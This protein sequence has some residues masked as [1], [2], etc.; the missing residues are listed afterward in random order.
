MPCT[1]I[2][3]SAY[4]CLLLVGIFGNAMSFSHMGSNAARYALRIPS[5]SMPVTRSLQ[6][7]RPA[8]SSASTPHVHRQRAWTVC[9][10]R[11]DD[12]GS[13]AD[14]TRTSIAIFAALGAVETGALTA[15]KLFGDGGGAAAV[16]S[17][18]GGGC[19]DVLSGPWADLFG[20]PLAAFG[21]A[22]YVAVLSLSLYPKLSRNGLGPSAVSAQGVGDGGDA[23]LHDEALLLGC[24]V[25]VTFSACLMGLLLFLQQFCALCITS[26]TISA[27]MFISAWRGPLLKSRSETAVISTTGA[28]I[29]LVTAFALFNVKSLQI[30]ESLD[31]GPR[32]PP[33]IT[34]HSS[35]RALSLASRMAAHDAR[36]FGAYWCSHCIN[37]KETLG[38]EAFVKLEY[39]E[40]DE[41]G[42]NSQKP[43]CRAEGV[44]GYPTWQ[45]DGKL[46]PGERSISELEEILDDIE[47]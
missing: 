39:V 13:T 16:C 24:A 32:S 10:T 12:D 28:L 19:A 41:D 5:V 42:D 26:A 33:A 46:F 40:C 38:M 25:M 4:R 15:D 22:G 34:Q 21:L 29:T 11:V 6:A 9:A 44:R 18:L 45:L 7:Q 17:A 2:R 23:S 8:L 35:P 3:A 43:L 36:M 30:E 31:D 27:A 1:Q 14:T 47:K 37:Q 20:V